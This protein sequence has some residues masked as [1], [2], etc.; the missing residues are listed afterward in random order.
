[1]VDE[2]TMNMLGDFIDLSERDFG[3]KEDYLPF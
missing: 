2:I 3:E 1:L